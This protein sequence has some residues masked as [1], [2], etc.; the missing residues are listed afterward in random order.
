MNWCDNQ[1]K[2]LKWTIELIGN[3]RRKD[4]ETPGRIKEWMKILGEFESW[5]RIDHELTRE[6][7]SDAPVRFGEWELKARINNPEMM[8]SGESNWKDSWNASDGWKEFSQSKIIMRGWQQVRIMNLW[9]KGYDW[10]EWSKI[11]KKSSSVF[12]SEYDD[13]KHHHEL[14]RYS[15]IKIGKVEPMMKRIWKILEKT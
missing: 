6:Y 13:E 2:D 12:Q 3:E 15:G 4:K 5:E 8:D 9:E 10:R 1:G 11:E 14:L 7:L